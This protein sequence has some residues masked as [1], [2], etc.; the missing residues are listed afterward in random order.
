[1]LSADYEEP[2]GRGSPQTPL[3]HNPSEDIGRSATPKP[4]P[5]K[6][7]VR[8][9]TADDRAAHRVFEKSRREAFK[10]RLT[11]LAS[12]LPDLQDTDPQ[13][14][15]K[16]VVVDESISYLKS[17]RSEYQAVTQRLRAVTSERDQLLTEV[18]HWRARAGIEMRQAN[19]PNKTTVEPYGES[20]LGA[21]E[22]SPPYRNPNG[23]RKIDK[24]STTEN[25]EPSAVNSFPLV[26]GG[27]EATNIPGPVG[28][29]GRFGEA[30][31][32]EDTTVPTQDI[33]GGATEP[34][35]M[36]FPSQPVITTCQSS[37][38]P[39]LSQFTDSTPQQEA[40][41]LSPGPPHMVNL[42][43]FQANG[44]THNG[45]PIQGFNM[46]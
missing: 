34:S 32:L 12:L 46:P 1:M 10:E 37:Q 23:V 44:L 18:N 45:M 38:A 29:W 33:P 24:P 40:V 31:P 20:P 39:E 11:V 27:I 25:A 43:G 14:L 9:F 3:K 4:R 5:R 7:R 42:A 8:N 36:I 15:S 35:S 19:I 22:L 26:P 21:I 16:H 6:K 41:F 2:S 13:R 17:Q 28:P 30:I